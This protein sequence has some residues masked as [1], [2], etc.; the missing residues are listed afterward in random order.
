MNRN[1]KSRRAEQPDPFRF[2]WRYVQQ[3][4]PDGAKQWVQAPLTPEDVLHPKKGDHI[5]ENTQQERDRR[6]LTDVL[7]WR[8]SGNPRAL[9]MSD[10]LID[11]GVRG[12]GNH[13]PDVSVFDGVNDPHGR[14]WG[15]FVVTA[16]EA[17]PVLV[18][19]VVSPDAHDRRARDNDVI[20]KV[21][22]YY[23]ARV[24]LYVIVDQERVGEPR[25]IVGYRR[26]TRKYV[27]MPLDEQGRLLLEPVRLLVGLREERVVCWDADTDKKIP[28]FTQMAQALTD[29][30]ARIRELEARGRNGG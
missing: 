3:I 15:T 11:W 12:L 8:L 1:G 17:R 18:I 28:D 25:Q 6:Y 5:L 21:R 22:E 13:S 20:I 29:A 7:K 14:N 27:P 16:E 9:V 10:C 2:G 19:E 23:R 26:G 24:S 4:G 30:Q